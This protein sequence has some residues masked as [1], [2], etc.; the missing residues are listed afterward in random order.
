MKEITVGGSFHS[1]S[2]GQKFWTK[3]WTKFGT[4]ETHCTVQYSGEHSKQLADGQFASQVRTE[5]NRSV[6]DFLRGDGGRLTPSGDDA[7]EPWSL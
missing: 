1:L 7:C 6:V 3:A 2:F 5:Q 4:R